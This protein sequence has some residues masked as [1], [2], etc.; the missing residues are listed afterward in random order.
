MNAD[1]IFRAL[2]ENPIAGNNPIHFYGES[3]D[4]GFC[5]GRALFVEKMLH[6]LNVKQEQ[7]YKVFV[8]GD[9]F[10]GHILWNYHVATMYI[11]AAGKKLMIDSLFDKV[12]DLESWFKKINKFAINQ[13]SP[14]FR[15]YFAGAHKFQARPGEFAKEDL[16]NPLY[17]NYFFDLLVWL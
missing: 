8:I 2:T 13:K 11:N 17:D 7:I 6:N 15:I 4:A 10:D 16:F 1:K 3:T 9:L 12:Y 14:V 5:F